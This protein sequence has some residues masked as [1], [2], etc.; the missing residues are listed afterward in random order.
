M[1][2][3]YNHWNTLIFSI[4]QYFNLFHI[5][6]LQPLENYKRIH[7]L[8]DSVNV[9]LVFIL[10]KN[11]KTVRRAGL[12]RMMLLFKSVKLFVIYR[13]SCEHW[14]NMKGYMETWHEVVK[15]SLFEMLLNEFSLITESPAD[16]NFKRSPVENFTVKCFGEFIAFASSNFFQLRPLWSDLY[17]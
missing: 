3:K 2:Q 1:L 16:C 7:G 17:K 11:T 12:F 6:T 10:F 15:Y 4:F 13:L 14:K 5:Q 8:P 9:S